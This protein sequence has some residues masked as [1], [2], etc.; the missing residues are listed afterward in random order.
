MTTAPPFDHLRRRFARQIAFVRA[1]L[2]PEGY[3]GLQ[4]S[5]GVIGSTAMPRPR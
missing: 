4:M 5:I 3:F 1:R 2:S